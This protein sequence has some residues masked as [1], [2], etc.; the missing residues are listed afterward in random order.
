MKDISLFSDFL[1]AL[2]VP[3]TEDYSNK[4]FAS[5]A[6]KSMFGLS[7][8]LDSYGIP[9][10]GLQIS[11]KSEL[12]KL[13]P[14]FL[15][16]TPQGFVIVT[17][18][19]GGHVDYLS[20]GQKE[21]IDIQ[22][23]EKA[24]NGIVLLAFP[25]EKSQEPDYPKH[26]LIENIN[27]GK[28]WVMWALLAALLAYA[29]VTNNIYSHWSTIAIMLVDIA[30]LTFSVMLVQKSLKIKNKAA[31][32][33]C[34]VLQ[35]GGC[36]SLMDKQISSFFGIFKWSEVGF[37]Y[38]S[39]SLLA[40]MIFPQ[41]IGALALCNIFCLPYTVWSIWYQKFRAKTWCTLCVSVQTSLWLLFFCYLFGGWEKLI[42]PIGW[43]FFVLVAAYGAVL[44]TLNAV[45]NVILKRIDNEKDTQA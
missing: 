31:D 42:F 4:Q 9:N 5:M 43:L 37:A 41:C 36:D 8:L 16:D 21:S 12:S 40:L 3:H 10:E 30:G 39:V 17:G 19:G 33:V 29:F 34:G 38:F 13:T 25:D 32:A 15:A 24:W 20:Q 28:R 45:D 22:E 26:R 23:F 14:P 1:Q 18:I 27:T 35:E 6:F 44:L 7:K 2:G 11:D